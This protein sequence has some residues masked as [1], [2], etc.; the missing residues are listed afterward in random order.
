[1]PFRWSIWDKSKPAGPP[2][3]IATCVRVAIFMSIEPKRAVARRKV[4][5]A[6]RRKPVS[7][8]PRVFKPDPGASMS[9]QV[10]FRSNGVVQTTTHKR[11]LQARRS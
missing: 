7:S 6:Q 3:M 5:V 2:P 4:A 1:M 10:S 11:P 9:L 8:R